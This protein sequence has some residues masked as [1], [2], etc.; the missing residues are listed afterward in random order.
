MTIKDL[1]LHLENELKGFK[2]S[3]IIYKRIIKNENKEIDL[4]YDDKNIDEIK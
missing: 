4:L 1:L 2:V 3:H